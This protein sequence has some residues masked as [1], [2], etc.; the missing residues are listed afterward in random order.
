MLGSTSP[1]SG[2]S[3]HS[4]GRTP[5]QRQGACSNR[6]HWLPRAATPGASSA[7]HWTLGAPGQRPSSERP[8][9]TAHPKGPPALEQRSCS[10]Q[11]P[12]S[13][14]QGRGDCGARPALK[15]PHLDPCLVQGRCLHLPAVSPADSSSS[16]A[17]WRHPRRVRRPQASASGRSCSGLG[18]PGR[19]GRAPACGP[20][21]KGFW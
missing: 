12:P 17:P 16:P 8:C 1:A 14:H 7:H 21:T 9:W 19:G 5:A 20:C 11:R 4:G 2:Q 3:A 18:P 13:V 6:S 10:R 15:P